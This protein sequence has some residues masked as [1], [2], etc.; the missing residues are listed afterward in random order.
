MITLHANL[1]IKYISAYLFDPKKIKCIFIFDIGQYPPSGPGFIQQ[2]QQNY[3]DGSDPS[4]K[5]F[6]F[7]D[8]TIR[9]AFIRKVY[10]ILGVG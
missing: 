4:V 5:G 1:Y 7:T 10:A 2:P 8:Q 3:G 6:D 9:R